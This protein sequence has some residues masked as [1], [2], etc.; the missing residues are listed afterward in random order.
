MKLKPDENGYY[1]GIILAHRFTVTAL[2]LVA[3][4]FIIKATVGSPVNNWT[5][6]PVIACMFAIAICAMIGV[7]VEFP[8]SPFLALR[9]MGWLAIGTWVLWVVFSGRIFVTPEY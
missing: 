5:F 9:I 1:P 7:F 8:R 6:L 3:L 2:I 4:L